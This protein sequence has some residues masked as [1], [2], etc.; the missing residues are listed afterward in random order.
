MNG[1]IYIGTIEQYGFLVEEYVNPEHTLML[2]VWGD[3]YT[4]IFE[5]VEIKKEN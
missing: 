3:G 1:W 5:I 4:E 2:Q